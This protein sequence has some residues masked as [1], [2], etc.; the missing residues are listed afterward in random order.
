MMM[1]NGNKLKPQERH[2]MNLRA[3]VIVCLVL[4]TLCILPS[5]TV[6]ARAWTVEPGVS[7]AGAYDD[8][9]DF[10]TKDETGDFY[11]VVKPSL[12]LGY[13][14]ERSNLNT[15]ADVAFI[16]Y[17]DETELDN[18]RYKLKLDGDTKVSERVVLEANGEY[19]KDNLLDSELEETGLVFD[20]EDRERFK[21]G[22]GM[23][24][25]LSQL[26]SLGLGYQ[27]ESTS[28]EDPDRVDRYI[29]SVITS[30][31]RAFNDGRDSIFVTP[32]YDF[33]DSTDVDS[34]NYS[35][36]VGWTHQSNEI[37]SLT[38]A[39]GG[40]FTEE[41]RP[42]QD[43]QDSSGFT[44]TFNYRKKG[45]RTVTS[46]RYDRVLAYDANDALREVDRFRLRFEYKFTERFLLGLDGRLVLSR[47]GLDEADDQ[48]SRYA[49]FNPRLDYALTERHILRLAYKYQEEYDDARTDD[50]KT[51][52]R[53]QVALTV[54]FRFPQT[55]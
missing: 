52:A 1:N 39:A 55:Y 41:E 8:N 16:N 43:K 47:L 33:R 17:R 14:S 34:K 42:G 29:N 10:A 51:A 32:R 50:E 25:G 53:N 11:S 54:V 13:L 30:I 28:Y 7:L 31:S 38:I 45:Q 22:A 21:G 12:T 27:F 40:R 44:G 26:T 48:N 2:M 15:T 19:I 6:H 18:T 4:W 35:L 3:P 46:L 37:G 36:R 49:E 24:F 5:G 9:V 23:R 20:R